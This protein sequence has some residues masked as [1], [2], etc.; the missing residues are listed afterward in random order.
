MTRRSYQLRGLHAAAALGGLP[1]TGPSDQDAAHRLGRRDVEVPAVVPLRCIVLCQEEVGLVDQGGS[2]EGLAGGLV[3]ELLGC[4]SPQ[5]VVDRRNHGV[6]R[7]LVVTGRIP[8]LRC[9][10][11]CGTML[12]PPK[13]A[14]NKE[15]CAFRL[16]R[17]SGI[18]VEGP[19]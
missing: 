16:E 11:H 15:E 8:G 13:F 4:Q 17:G 1:A 14:V 7:V 3:G 2:T 19:W 5:L 9:V 6:R 18:L 10:G 12:A